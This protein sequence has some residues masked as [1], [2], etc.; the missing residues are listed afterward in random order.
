MLLDLYEIYLYMTLVEIVMEVH[1]EKDVVI[2]HGKM[3]Q[4]WLSEKTSPL[5]GGCFKRNRCC[6]D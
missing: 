5:Q 6:H 3:N 2:H 1:G 4:S